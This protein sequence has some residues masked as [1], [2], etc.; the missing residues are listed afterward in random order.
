MLQHAYRN[1]HVR[2]LDVDRS[3]SKLGIRQDPLET[4]DYVEIAELRGD[5]RSFAAA[6]QRRDGTLGAEQ[7]LPQLNVA[8][9]LSRDAGTRQARS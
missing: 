3:C 2:H 7:R 6:Q 4:L 5:Q 1:R 9:E 8:T